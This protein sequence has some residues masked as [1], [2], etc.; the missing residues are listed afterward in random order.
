MIPIV[1]GVIYFLEFLK[2]SS[3]NHSCIIYFLNGLFLIVKYVDISSSV[4]V[5]TLHDSF[6]VEEVIL[7]ILSSFKT[8]FRRFSDN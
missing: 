7:L 2:A 3:C 8:L 5:S 1:L 4:D 6:N